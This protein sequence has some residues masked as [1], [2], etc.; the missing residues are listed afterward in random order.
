MSVKRVE[1]CLCVC[2]CKTGSLI[3]R[4]F[5]FFFVRMIIKSWLSKK[6]GPLAL[7]IPPLSW[8]QE[9]LGWI[10]FFCPFIYFWATWMQ[11]ECYKEK[12]GYSQKNQSTGNIHRLFLILYSSGRL[13]VLFQEFSLAGQPALIRLSLSLAWSHCISYHLNMWCDKI[14]QERYFPSITWHLFCL[15]Q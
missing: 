9:I 3:S 4:I 6:V 8:R 15:P 14:F 11:M 7:F 10:Q 2:M 5:F 12:L 13:R 1:F